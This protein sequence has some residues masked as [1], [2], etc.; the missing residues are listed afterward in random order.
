MNEQERAAKN[1]ET[2]RSMMERATVYRMISGP[3]ALLGGGLVILV[4]FLAPWECWSWKWTWIGV[5]GLV[6][7]FNTVLVVRKAKREGA[8][9]FS[10]GLR[11]GIRSLFPAMM[12]GAVVSLRD[13]APVALAMVW[14]LCYGVALMS[15]VSFAPRSLWVLGAA[16]LASGLFCVLRP[17]V[18]LSCDCQSHPSEGGNL[19]MMVTFGGFHLVY[20]LY[21]ILVENKRR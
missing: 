1:L 8:P 2:I 4:G 13:F 14:T 21:V 7:L 10:A 6:A 17:S 3:T 5:A 18:F 12:V 15:T 9:V 16:F 20:G 11:M 19:L